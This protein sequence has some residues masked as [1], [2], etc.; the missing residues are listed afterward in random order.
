MSTTF[1]SGTDRIVK[2]VVLKAPLAKVWRALTVAGEFGQWFQVN[3]QGETFAVG[4]EFSGPVLHPGYEHLRMTGWVESLEPMSLFSFRWHPYAV[5][6]EV[7]YT[8]EATTLV[9][10]TLTEIPEGIR[11]TVIESGF[12]QLPSGRQAEAFRMNS[13]GWEDQMDNIAAYVAGQP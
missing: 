11:L 12:D 2:E 1:P 5:D 4:Q 7:D 8:T 13:G 3:L 10:F 9:A 6:P